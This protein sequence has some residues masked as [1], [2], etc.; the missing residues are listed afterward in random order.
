MDRLSFRLS[1]NLFLDLW[2]HFC[3]HFPVEKLFGNPIISYSH[4]PCLSHLV[5][6]FQGCCIEIFRGQH[7]LELKTA[8]WCYVCVTG[9]FG[10]ITQT[11]LYASSILSIF[12]KNTTGHVHTLVLRVMSLS[13]QTLFANLPNTILDKKFIYKYTG[14]SQKIR[15]LWKNSFFFLF[16]DLIQKVI[17]HIF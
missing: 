10:G 3:L 6:L 14:T 5:L 15:I 9:I 4:V 2:M 17:R 13:H 16:H 1:L 12:Q 11:I 7:C 8:I